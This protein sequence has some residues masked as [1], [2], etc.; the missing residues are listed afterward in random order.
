MYNPTGT[1]APPPTSAPGNT[2]E[3]ALRLL[4]SF[5]F[6]NNSGEPLIQDALAMPSWNLSKD[7]PR[8]GAGTPSQPATALQDTDVPS[9]NPFLASQR[10]ALALDAL[11]GGTTAGG[12]PR[13]SGSGEGGTSSQLEALISG[14]PSPFVDE[15]KLV[16]RAELEQL[17]LK[18]IG[19]SK[20]DS[21]RVERTYTVCATL[22]F[23]LEWCFWVMVFLG[24]DVFGW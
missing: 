1:S 2:H 5:S 9:S 12:Q 16:S 3:A 20:F 14:R 24:G 4:H 11:L 13:G 18:E 22:C 21:V 7:E 8:E 15:H 19:S 6:P 10:P 17:L 23:C